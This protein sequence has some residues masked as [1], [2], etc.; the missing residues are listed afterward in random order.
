MGPTWGRPTPGFGRLGGPSHPP[1]SRAGHV[2][3]VS[4]FHGVHPP[5]HAFVHVQILK[6]KIWHKKRELCRIGIRGVQ[7]LLI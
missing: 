4:R 7:T 6:I 1:L 2:S 3:F 5:T